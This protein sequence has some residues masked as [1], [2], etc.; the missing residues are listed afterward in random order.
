MEH[1]VFNRLVAKLEP[2]AYDGGSEIKNS[3][4]AMLMP[5]LKRIMSHQT[6]RIEI[7]T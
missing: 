5:Q 3:V 4:T 6:N 2:V 7:K 1:G